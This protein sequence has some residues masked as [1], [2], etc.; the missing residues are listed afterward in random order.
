MAL[1]AAD[2]L[3]TVKDPQREY[4]YSIVFPEYN[5]LPVA[6]LYPQGIDA[7]DKSMLHLGKMDMFKK[8]MSQ[9]FATQNPALFTIGYVAQIS[10]YL[11]GGIDMYNLKGVW[12]SSK[13]EVKQLQWGRDTFCFAGKDLSSKTATLEF[14]NDE[15]NICY[16]FWMQFHHAMA[17]EVAYFAGA[18]SLCYTAS[19][20]PGKRDSVFNL[21][22]RQYKNDKRAI[23]RAV[24][25]F[26]VMVSGVS[27]TIPDKSSNGISKVLVDICWD[28]FTPSKPSTLVQLA[29]G[30]I[31]AL[32]FTEAKHSGWA[33]TD[34]LKNATHGA[35][36]AD[37]AIDAEAL[38]AGFIEQGL[39]GGFSSIIESAKNYP[40]EGNSEGS[41]HEVV[42]PPPNSDPEPSGLELPEVTS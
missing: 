26:N 40:Y 13:S 9:L 32:S 25:L 21:E 37:L 22:I 38:A 6:L 3:N 39:E 29:E 42:K 10:R 24:T 27:L 8:I 36:I 30:L 28:G 33:G 34:Y 20:I 31:P 17:M 15:D 16:W 2:M 35:S 19:A 4:L 41:Y 18:S 23:S 14:I 5:W 7:T 1:V 12:P 11:G